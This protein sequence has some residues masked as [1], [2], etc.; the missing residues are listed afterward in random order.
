[1]LSARSWKRAC[2]VEVPVPL[3][4][5]RNDPV[6]ESVL[7]I[8]EEGRVREKEQT[9]FYRRLASEAE[10]RGDA[11]LAE[12]LNALHA[13]EQ[14]HLSRLTARL[15]ELGGTP[16]E[17]AVSPS[18]SPALGDWESVARFREE[19]EVDWYRGVLERGL[20]ATSEVLVREILES[21]EHHARELGGKW[22]SA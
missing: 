14:H 21:E 16:G 6:K 19:R 1:M 10:L 11:E 20:D 12:R 8:L 18:D 13:D 9:L 3:G 7:E 4:S 2:G 22:M 5:R 15:L 17:M